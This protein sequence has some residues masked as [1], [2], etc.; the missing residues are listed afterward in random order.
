MEELITVIINVYN[1][2]KFIRK[3]LDS[4]INQTY[5]NLEI[6]IINDGS[7]DNTLKICESF[8]DERIRIITQRNM[9]IS[10]ARNVGIENA[11]GEYIFFVD[12]DDFIQ[13]D[14]IEYLYNLCKNNNTKMSVCMPLAIYDYNI[15]VKQQQEIIKI[16]SGKDFLKEI[17]LSKNFTGNVW[18]KL[19]KKE[20]FQKYK[21]EDRIISDVVVIYKMVMDLDRIAYSNQIKYY[22][23]RHQSSITGKNHEERT[24][25][26]YRAVFER[27]NYIKAIYPDFIENEIGLMLMIIY[28]YTKDGD[29]LHEFLKEQNAI[30][31][32]RKLFSFKV[33]VA[34]ISHKEKLKISLF[35]IN[36]QLYRYIARKYNS[37][38]Y[39]YFM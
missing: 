27:Y 7:T 12:S 5:K 24:I 37:L 21:F 28:C 9:W 22:Y 39:K 14:I 6:L 19:A 34:T 33:L 32:Y 8:N 13:R 18:N 31:N 16:V 17:L 23:L 20:I 29:K 11:N 4:V 10:L 2:E 1:G 35:F 25:D 3:C 15:K 26:L 30:N 38:K 36:P